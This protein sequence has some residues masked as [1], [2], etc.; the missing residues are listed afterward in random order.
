MENVFSW[1][2]AKKKID[3]LS[4][5]VAEYTASTVAKEAMGLKSSLLD[6][7]HDEKVTIYGDNRSR[8]S[9]ISFKN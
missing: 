1:N 9:W 3:S 6:F 5:T 8:S 4:S 7:N 2:S